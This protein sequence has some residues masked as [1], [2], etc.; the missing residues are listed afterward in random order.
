MFTAAWYFP[1]LS[2]SFDSLQPLFLALFIPREVRQKRY[3]YYYFL[4]WYKEVNYPK[5]RGTM[6]TVYLECFD[7]K[8]QTDRHGMGAERMDMCRQDSCTL[9]MDASTRY[10]EVWVSPIDQLTD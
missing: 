10:V 8:L 1:K 9:E 2:A 3:H 4:T 7:Q 6:E 5:G